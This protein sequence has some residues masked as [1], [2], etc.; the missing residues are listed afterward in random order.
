MDCLLELEILANKRQRNALKAQGVASV[1]CDSF[2]WDNKGEFV[3]SMPYPEGRCYNADGPIPV[4][5]S[6]GEKTSGWSIKNK[7]TKLQECRQR[8][9]AQLEENG[10]NGVRMFCGT[11]SSD[12]VLKALDN[13]RTNRKIKGGFAVQAKR[14]L[15]ENPEDPALREHY[16]KAQGEFEEAKKQAKEAYNKVKK[17]HGSKVVSEAEWRERHHWESACW[18]K[19][20]AAF[21]WPCG[22]GSSNPMLQALDDARTNRRIK[23][24]FMAR[25]RKALERNPNDS[26]LQERYEKAQEEFEEAKKQ[27]KAVYKSTKEIHGDRVISE[28]EWS[29]KN[30]WELACWKKKRAAFLASQQYSQTASTTTDTKEADRSL[31]SGSD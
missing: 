18:R 15:E 7:K 8:I 13:I 23:G 22:T 4:M 31:S 10:S 12:P 28:V 30:Y 14:S 16:E 27:S 9:L 24:G 1:I 3:W 6:A 21:L 2:I 29:E 26:V 11:E 17:T 20:R 25:V 19:K 5:P